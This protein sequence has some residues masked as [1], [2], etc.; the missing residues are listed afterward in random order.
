[1]DDD[2]E[3]NQP[4]LQPQTNY[5]LVSLARYGPS[6][7]DNGNLTSHEPLSLQSQFNYNLASLARYGPSLSD[8]GN[9]AY[10]GSSSRL[11][12][13]YN[14][15]GGYLNQEAPMNLG[16]NQVPNQVFNQVSTAT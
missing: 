1:M 7:S 14:I 6:L 5:N 2:L 11:D 4:L 8:D 13:N 15:A 16:N 9:L 3:S 10:T 12:A